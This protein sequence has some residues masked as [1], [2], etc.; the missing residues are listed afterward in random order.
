MTLLEAIILGIIQG[1]SE[2]LPISSSGHLALGHAL[3]GLEE[4]GLLFSIVVHVGT[5]IP[6]VAIFW[7][8]IWALIKRPFQKMTLLLIIATIP[9]AVIG[10]LFEDM[11]ESAFASLTFVAF[12][13]VITGLVLLF[14][15]RLKKTTKPAEDI[16]RLDALLIG[17]AQA[18]AI[19]PGISRSG[20]TIAAALARGTRRE[21]AAKFAFLMSVP[22]ILGALVLQI[23]H[24]LRG[25]TQIHDLNLLNLGAGFITAAASGYFAI[26][27]MLKAVQKAKLR[28]FAYYVLALA[29][30]I[31]IWTLILN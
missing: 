15:D 3:F 23:A 11:V 5:L 10:L 29:T 26:N 22:I 27:F 30:A 21:D 19:L 13:F 4:E 18:I 12:G 20:S 28:Y 6:V 31:T 25:G 17:L 16:T 9:A 1:L 24:L 7:Q 8:D 2:F 14:T